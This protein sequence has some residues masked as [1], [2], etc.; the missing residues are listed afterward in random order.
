M[1]IISIVNQKGGCGKTT[2]AVNVAAAFAELGRKVLLIDFDPQAHVTVG[3]GYDPD[4]FDW[5]IY[6]VLRQA[7][8]LVEKA[9][10]QT[11]VAGLDLVPCNMLLASAD[12]HLATVFDKEVLLTRCLCNAEYT[13]DLCVIDCPPS[14]GLLTLNALMA[15]MD[16]I[17]PVQSYYYDLIGLKRLLETIQVMQDRL[18]PCSSDQVRLLLTFVDERAGFSQYV[19]QQVRETFGPSVFNTVIHRNAPLAEAP[20]AGKPVLTYAPNSR[21]AVDYRALACEMLDEPDGREEPPPADVKAPPGVPKRL[22][23]LLA[24][25]PSARYKSWRSRFGPGALEST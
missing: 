7:D 1:R 11:S 6:D 2:T 16:V 19:R 20:S 18:E 3:L 21:G 14:L 13:Y 24:D 10:V 5:T 8:G 9:V 12:V 22:A 17:V 4:S 25:T 15:S 23:A